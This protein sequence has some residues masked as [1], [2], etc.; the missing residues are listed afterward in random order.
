MFPLSK[1][2]LN[3]QERQ[4]NSLI[5]MLSLS[6][7]NMS[8]ATSNGDR[9]SSDY[10]DGMLWKV[11]IYDKSCQDLIGPLMKVSRACIQDTSLFIPNRNE[12]PYYRSASY[13]S[14]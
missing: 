8:T 12:H 6:D 14:S 10:Y 1:M 11:L 4:R 5:Q 13:T 7:N 2:S 9:Q 3:I